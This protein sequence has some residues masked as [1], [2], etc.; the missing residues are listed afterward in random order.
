M[1]WT[2]KIRV[3]HCSGSIKFNNI[4]LLLYYAIYA[5]ICTDMIIFMP[6]KPK[7]KKISSKKCNCLQREKKTSIDLLQ[8]D[9]ERAQDINSI[10]KTLNI[11]Y[12]N[13]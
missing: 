12:H 13:S 9:S 2:F 6:V 3:G 10:N 8:S 7:R 4:I 1:E 11:I 5:I